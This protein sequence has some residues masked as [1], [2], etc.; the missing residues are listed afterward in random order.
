MLVDFI[1]EK[2]RTVR[3]THVSGILHLA[4]SLLSY[5]FIEAYSVF[6]VMAGDYKEM[7]T[8]IIA[9]ITAGYHFGLVGFG[10]V[11]RV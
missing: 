10:S 2:W 7:M 1:S 9:V 4:V 11:V 3:S 5:P 6:Q 8:A